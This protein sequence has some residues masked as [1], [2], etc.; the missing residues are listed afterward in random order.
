VNVTRTDNGAAILLPFSPPSAGPPSL[1]WST[2][3]GLTGGGLTGGQI[4]GVV[5]AVLA[6]VGLIGFGV[7]V[8]YRRRNANTADTDYAPHD[9]SIEDGPKQCGSSTRCAM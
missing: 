6:A 2:G 4:F 3:S 9:N 5:I 8:Y 7:Y 1:T